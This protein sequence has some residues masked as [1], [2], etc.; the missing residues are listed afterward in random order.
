MKAKVIR[1]GHLAPKIIV[2]DGLPGCGKSMLSHILASF[3]RTEVMTFSY[4]LEFI[5]TLVYLEKITSDAAEAMIR[6]IT[7][8]K[9]YNLMMSRE[10]NFR[11]SD[12]SSIFKNQS[13]LRYIKRLFEKGDE[14]IPNLIKKRDPILIITT[15]QMT[16]LSKPLFQSLGSRLFFIELVRH[17]LYMIKQHEVI[18]RQWRTSQIRDFDLQIEFNNQQI[19]FYAFGYEEKFIE[20][21]P[22]EKGILFID[23]FTNIAEKTKSEINKKYGHRLLT[24]SFE[25]FVVNPFPYVGK[26]AEAID[27]D[28][29]KKTI[30][31][32]KRQK[33]PRKKIADG[34]SLDIYKRFGWE[35]S[36]KG[37]NEKDEL[38]ER[39]NYVVSKNIKDYNIKLLDK[40]IEEYEKSYSD[41]LKR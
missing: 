35:P 14:E 7:D 19:P 36:K 37:Y 2:I 17:P 5:L 15:H 33:V 41:F 20:A 27:S 29:T 3:D 28:V 9:I 21:S 8:L 16:A 23:R 1:N 40:I 32:M 34:L 30:K 22:I 10:V 38:D 6:N 31:E 24:I 4:E 18:Q 12:Q 25:D 39:Y 26:I 13:S 11:P